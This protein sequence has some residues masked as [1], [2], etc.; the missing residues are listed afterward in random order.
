MRN[1]GWYGHAFGMSRHL[2]EALLYW[3]NPADGMKRMF[4]CKLI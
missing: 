1:G 4:A 2:G 3:E